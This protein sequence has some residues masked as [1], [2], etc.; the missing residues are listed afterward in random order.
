MSSYGLVNTIQ[1]PT[2][3]G[4]TQPELLKFEVEFAAHC[5]RVQ[6]VNSG[7]LASQRIKAATIRQCMKPRLLQSLCILGRIENASSVEQ[8]TDD[9][10]QAWFD[11]RLASTICDL[12]DRVKEALSTVKFKSSP[13]HP[14]GATENLVFDTIAALDEYNASSIINDGDQC[15]EL[16][17][18]LARKLE[19]PELKQ[20]V[21][22]QIRLWK[23]EQKGDLKFFTNTISTLAAQVHIVQCASQKLKRKHGHSRDTGKQNTRSGEPES[24]RARRGSRSANKVVEKPRQNAETAADKFNAGMHPISKCPVTSKEKRKELLD[25]HFGNKK[26]NSNSAKV[27]ALR[28]DP[29]QWLSVTPALTTPPS[30]QASSKPSPKGTLAL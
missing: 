16:I 7:R 8:A 17:V 12:S 28:S 27:S 11:S 22:D 19:P 1:A 9:A 25:E 3:E 30:Q 4:A 10:V 13:R 15:K 29:R 23:K 24:K 26:G 6:D 5:E 18:K 20:I 14:S 2:L 21:M